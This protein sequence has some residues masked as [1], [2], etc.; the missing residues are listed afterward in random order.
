MSRHRFNLN[1]KTVITNPPA[2]LVVTFGPHEVSIGWPL[3]NLISAKEVIK[4]V[5]DDEHLAGADE[6]MSRMAL[7]SMLFG[8]K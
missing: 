2:G 3:V 4:R 7:M 8:F 5:S 6:E 1:G